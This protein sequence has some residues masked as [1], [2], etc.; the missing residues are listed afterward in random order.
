MGGANVVGV[1]G[2]AD[3][4]DQ[5]PG[6][7]IS[8]DQREGAAF[9]DIDAITRL[10]ERAAGDPVE[11]LERVETLQRHAAERV[12]AADNRRVNDIRGDQ[13]LGRGERLTA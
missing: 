6:V 1:R 13:S 2:L 10:T 9:A 12:E 4:F 7:A 5:D 11:G 3:A 8:L